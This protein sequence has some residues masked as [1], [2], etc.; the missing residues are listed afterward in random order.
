[1]LESVSKLVYCP[2]LNSVFT[3]NK[4]ELSF[5]EN[6][7][8]ETIR[9]F[10]KV[11]LE[12]I[13]VDESSDLHLC[14]C[15][16]NKG[17]ISALCEPEDGHSVLGYLKPYLDNFSLVIFP[18][19]GKVKSYVL[20]PKNSFLSNIHQNPGILLVSNLEA[21]IYIDGRIGEDYIFFG[22]SREGLH[23]KIDSGL[24]LKENIRKYHHFEEYLK[25]YNKSSE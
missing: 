16:G 24:L 13:V 18:D 1:M 19:S 4:K 20:N 15:L 14:A 9:H 8:I 21:G 11:V 3:K 2:N 7:P 17:A 5:L 23:N 6:M 10:L 22:R 12:N 25:Y